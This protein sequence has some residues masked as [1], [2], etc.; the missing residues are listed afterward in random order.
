RGLTAMSPIKKQPCGY[1][2]TNRSD[3]KMDI[4]LIKGVSNKTRWIREKAERQIRG[5]EMTIDEKILAIHN[6]DEEIELQFYSIKDV[7]S[8]TKKK[9]K[10]QRY[11]DSDFP[12]YAFVDI[13]GIHCFALLGEYEYK[14]F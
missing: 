4:E 1:Y 13:E 6:R 3:E 12:Y 7:E 11:F 2:T 10:T 14:A 9:V 5:L 8:F